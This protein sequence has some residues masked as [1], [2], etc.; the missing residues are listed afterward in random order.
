LTWGS[1]FSTLE[2]VLKLTPARLATSLRVGRPSG[3]ADPPVGFV[4]FTMSR[5]RP[6]E[7]RHLSWP[8]GGCNRHEWPCRKRPLSRRCGP[9]SRVLCLSLHVSC[10]DPAGCGEVG[11]ARS[12]SFRLSSKEP[13][14]E[15]VSESGCDGL[16]RLRVRAQTRHLLPLK[17]RLARLGG[18]GQEPQ[19]NALREAMRQRSP[20][21]AGPNRLSRSEGRRRGRT[22]EHAHATGVG[23]EGLATW[24]GLERLPPPG[25]SANRSGKP[26]S[27]G[28]SF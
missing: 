25:R 16:L 27:T 8:S 9:G 7:L 20:Q 14:D 1:S 11:G 26:C 24:R 10:P 3:S 17:R 19:G 4:S 13:A 23:G 22:R 21:G 15:D 18:H 28:C 6:V 12:C 5:P 2:T